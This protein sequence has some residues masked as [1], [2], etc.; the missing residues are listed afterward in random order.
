MALSRDRIFKAADQ[1]IRSGKVEKAVA[2][3]EKWVASNPKDWN[4]I[5]Q[6]G[7]LYAR[8]GRNKDAIGKYSQIA[9]YYRQDGFN[10]RAIATHKMILRLD[11]QNEKAMRNLAELQVMQGLLM[12]AK[13]QYQAL[14]ELYTK[15][16]HKKHA[17][18]VFK[19][20]AEIDPSDLK[21]RYKFA[22][23]PRAGGQGRGSGCGVRGHRGRVH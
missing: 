15:A 1:C 21:V 12:E 11:P 5:R 8:L 14:V 13:A 23:V 10:V 9:D 19:K 2:E 18:E 7:D 22:R 20:L 4:T 16:G 3:Y 6:I 17:A